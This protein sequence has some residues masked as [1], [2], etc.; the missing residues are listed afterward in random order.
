L[1]E[2][3]KDIYLHSQ[4]TGESKKGETMFKQYKNLNNL[5]I[6]TY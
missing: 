1:E 6:I 5:P 2:K 4:N 3:D